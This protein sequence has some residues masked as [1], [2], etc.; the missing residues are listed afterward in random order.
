MA[1]QRLGREDMPRLIAEM[2][3]WSEDAPFV[4]R[5][6]AAGLCEPALLKS[7]EE[8]VEVLEILDRITRSMAGASDRRGEG[9]RVLREALG[10]CWSV[11]AAAAPENARPYME[12]WLRSKDKDVAWVMK[13]NLSKARMATVMEATPARAKRMPAAKGKAA[14][15]AKPAAKAK[16]PTKR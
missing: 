2:Q 8:A 16:A 13:S 6:A 1:L 9:F 15:K 11:A 5:A 12:K 7:Q 10:Y 3:D 14:A 4:Q